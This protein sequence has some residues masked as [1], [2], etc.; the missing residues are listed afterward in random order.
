MGK[1]RERERERESERRKK[2]QG[3]NA[4]TQK[5]EEKNVKQPVLL[6][7]SVTMNHVD[8]KCTFVVLAWKIQL[9]EN[10]YSPLGK[11]R[12]PRL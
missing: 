10:I 8:K 9:N 11:P 7:V 4:H 2:K 6:F 3:R 1:E 5:K 12:R